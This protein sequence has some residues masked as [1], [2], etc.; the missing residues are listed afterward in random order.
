MKK[1]LPFLFVVFVGCGSADS[2]KE[3]CEENDGSWVCP[4]GE[5]TVCRCEYSDLPS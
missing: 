5:L 2:N 1:I 3:Y 4:D